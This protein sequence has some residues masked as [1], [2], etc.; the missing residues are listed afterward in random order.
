MVEL[1]DCS[2]LMA[3]YHSRFGAKKAAKWVVSSVQGLEMR[4]SVRAMQAMAS[5]RSSRDERM[6]AAFFNTSKLSK[7]RPACP[8]QRLARAWA[9][10]DFQSC[11]VACFFS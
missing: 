2:Y 7:R 10:Y 5:L 8:L 4:M 3:M 1:V 6:S 11:S 9:R